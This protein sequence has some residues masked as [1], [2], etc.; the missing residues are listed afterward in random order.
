[1]DVYFGELEAS[2]KLGALHVWPENKKVA[3]FL[4]L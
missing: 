4:T 3:I 1:M 2:L